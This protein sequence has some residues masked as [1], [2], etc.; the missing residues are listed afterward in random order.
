MQGEALD[1]MLGSCE[2]SERSAERSEALSKHS[3]NRA[4]NGLS[5]PTVDTRPQPSSFRRCEQVKRKPHT[6]TR[7]LANPLV[8]FQKSQGPYRFAARHRPQER[9]RAATKSQALGKTPVI[10]IPSRL[11]HRRGRNSGIRAVAHRTPC[12]G[13]KDSFVAHS[14]EPSPPRT[15]SEYPDCHSPTRRSERLSHKSEA[16]P[17]F[18]R[19][20][21]Q[22]STTP[23][24]LPPGGG[25][26]VRSDDRERLR[27][28]EEPVRGSVTREATDVVHCESL[29]ED[30]KAPKPTSKPRTRPSSSPRDRKEKTRSL[31]SLGMEKRGATPGITQGPRSGLPLTLL[32]LAAGVFRGSFLLQRKS[33]HT[34]DVLGHSRGP[35][36]DVVVSNRL[37][38]G[39]EKRNL[40]Q[41]THRTASCRQPY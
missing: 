40:F 15:L 39:D 41:F 24:S 23:H 22:I 1:S 16:I 10:P 8:L 33:G 20:F 27:R 5:V 25:P 6:V 26:G 9:R 28:C 19:R 21:V 34:R 36:I 14:V 29:S 7:F 11:R 12:G 32:V 4:A 17:L 3:V 2:R 18:E 30:R 13:S 35:C 31:R 38:I 37:H